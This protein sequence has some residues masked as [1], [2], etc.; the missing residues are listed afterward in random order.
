MARHVPVSNRKKRSSFKQL[1]VESLEDRSLPSFVAAPMFA[2]GNNVGGSFPQS[3]R[4]IAIAVG[5]FNSDGKMD[6][7]TANGSG[8]GISLLRGNGLGGFLPCL[9]FATSST[10]NAITA[11]DV[12]GDGRMD[13]VVGSSANDTVSILRGNGNGTF[14]AALDLRGRRR[15]S[16]H[17]RRRR[18][19]RRQKGSRHCE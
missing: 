12:N 14:K 10:P 17:R 6:V 19:Q 1:H 7:V 4:P 5:D 15:P 8:V 13:I 2:V 11:A 18:E 9:N 16:K 3:S